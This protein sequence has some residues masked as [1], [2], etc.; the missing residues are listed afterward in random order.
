MHVVCWLQ[1]VAVASA[2][3][4]VARLVRHEPQ[5][6]S[7]PELSAELLQEW[8]ANFTGM[9]E[10][11]KE[12]FPE[13]RGPGEGGPDWWGGMV[14]GQRQGRWGGP[15]CGGRGQ[16]VR[17]QRQGRGKGRASCCLQQGLK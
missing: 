4:D 13:V 15:D 16:A 17:E 10:Y 1:A 11:A 12:V 6:V 2:L 8:V 14:R 7:G 3:W 9:V 5:R